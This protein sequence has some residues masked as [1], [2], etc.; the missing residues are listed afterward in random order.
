MATEVTGLWEELVSR[1]EFRG[2]IV[3]ITVIDQPAAARVKDD[4]LESLYRMAA[5]GVRIS[6]PADDS[7]EGIYGETE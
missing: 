5:E 3:R 7:R 2:H 4:W 6:R 1:P